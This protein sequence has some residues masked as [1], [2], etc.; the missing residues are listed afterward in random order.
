VWDRKTDAADADI[1]FDPL[2]RI[3]IGQGVA[4]FL[5]AMVAVLRMR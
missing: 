3:V 1:F 2:N 5:T 4:Q